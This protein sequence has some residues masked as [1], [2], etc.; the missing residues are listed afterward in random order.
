MK[1]IFLRIT[2]IKIYQ[3]FSVLGILTLL[4]LFG[5]SFF[6]NPGSDDFDM[7]YESQV[8]PLLQLQFRRYNDWSGRYFSNG[9]ISLDPLFYNNFL[10]IKI[11]P[12][13]LLFLFIFS[14]YVFISSLKILSTLKQKIA[15][16]GLIV[17]LFVYQMPDVCEGFY[18]IP[19]S[20]TNFLPT[21]LALLYFSFLIEYYWSKKNIY[22]FVSIGFLIA[23]IGCNELS[24]VIFFLIHLVLIGYNFFVLKKINKPL[25]IMFLISIIFS[26]IEVLAPGNAIRGS[27]ILEKHNFLFSV[28]KSLQFVFIYTFKWLPI[29]MICGLF[30]LNYIIIIIKKINSNYIIHPLLSFLFILILIFTA[31]FPGFWSLNGQPPNRSLNTLYLYFIF[32]S[33]YFLITIVYYFNFVKKVELNLPNHIQIMIGVIIITFFASD[34]NI[35]TSYQDLFSLKAYKYNIEMISRFKAIQNCKKSDCVLEPLI[36]KPSSIF[37]VEDF[38]LTSDKNN[39]KNL[40][41]A[42]Y[43]RKKSIVVKSGKYF[44]TE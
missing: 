7:A 30:S 16:I 11:V 44:F 39:W 25:V 23:A 42:R 43:Y 14:L 6:N 18:W 24:V 41:V 1:N 8:E 21:I 10:I 9:L 32:A 13:V 17:F 12:N 35:V 31:V 5:L 3:L 2:Q 37:S 40:E 34:N 22:L 27:L 15:F 26:L 20:I 29:I 28:L 4:P 36:N 33:I 38:A 19:G